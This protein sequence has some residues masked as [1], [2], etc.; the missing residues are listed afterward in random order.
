ML[1]CVT[2]KQVFKSLSLSYHTPPANPSFGMTPTVDNTFYFQKSP[3]QS[4]DELDPFR[5][6]LLKIVLMY[7]PFQVK[8]APCFCHFLRP[9]WCCMQLSFSP[10]VRNFLCL[11]SWKFRLVWSSGSN[12]RAKNIFW[13]AQNLLKKWP[14]LANFSIFLHNSI[15]MSKNQFQMI[16]K[17]RLLPESI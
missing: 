4:F 13:E 15:E 11:L 9:K 7:R 1:C 10:L 2:L 14:S 12:F 8:F 6:G 17:S 5:M 16:V 3:P